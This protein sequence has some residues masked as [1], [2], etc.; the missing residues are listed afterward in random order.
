MHACP[1]RLFSL[2]TLYLSTTLYIMPLS[3]R[4]KRPA[5]CASESSSRPLKRPAA[6]AAKPL[7]AQGQEQLLRP[8]TVVAAIREAFE[9]HS[10]ARC[11]TKMKQYMRNKFS[12]LGLAAPVRRGLQRS[13]LAGLKPDER[14]L[15][16]LVQ[17][18][19][20]HEQR[21]FHLCAVDLANEYSHL[22][23]TLDVV[24]EMIRDEAKGQWWD[25]VD[26][27]AAHAVASFVKRNPSAGRKHMDQWIRDDCMWIRRAA[28]LHQLLSHKDTDSELLERYIAR[29]KHEEDFFIRKAI[30]WALR[31]LSRYDPARVRA[32]L[33]RHDLSTL[34]VRE[35]SKHL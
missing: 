23:T 32:I 31:Q 24:E 17:R 20:A 3:R 11:A 4:Q 5:A 18:L 26:L 29:T 6:S 10:D 25:I 28:L 2:S 19:W 16:M 21:E 13:I 7:G 8:E 33:S 34:S 27:L 30:G 35:A 9:A 15:T 12:F 14:Y 1:P 22:W